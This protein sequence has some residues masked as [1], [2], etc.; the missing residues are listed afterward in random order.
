MCCIRVL[1]PQNLA[2]KANTKSVSLLFHFCPLSLFPPPTTYK[3]CCVI[4]QPSLNVWESKLVN[5]KPAFK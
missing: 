3:C 5:Q 1:S 4:F 2:P